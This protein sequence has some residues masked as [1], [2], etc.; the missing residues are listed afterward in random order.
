MASKGPKCPSSWQFRQWI[1]QC[2]RTNVPARNNKGYP[3]SIFT[4]SLCPRFLSMISPPPRQ[5]QRFAKTTWTP[6]TPIWSML[7]K[8]HEAANTLNTDTGGRGKTGE[9]SREFCKTLSGKW[10]PATRGSPSRQ[11]AIFFRYYVQETCK[12]N[13]RL[14]RHLRLL[15]RFYREFKT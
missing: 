9:C 11:R 4:I 10:V 2:R 13:T 14:F 7:G 12:R 3:F 15:I 5:I 1:S 8:P 6:P